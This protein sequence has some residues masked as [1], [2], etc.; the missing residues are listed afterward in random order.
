MGDICFKDLDGNGSIDVGDKEYCGLGILILE[1]NLNL[2]FGY[3]GF[4]FL[5]VFGSV[6]NFKL[7]NGNKYFYEGMNFKLNMLKF[8]LNVWIF[9][10]RNMDVFCV[11]Y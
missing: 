3:K 6:W 10:N 1:V 8:I 2:L 9:D 11:V 7:Y 5:I 4:D